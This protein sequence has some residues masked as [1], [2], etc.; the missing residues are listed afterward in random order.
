MSFY[1]FLQ[2]YNDQLDAISKRKD[3]EINRQS[4]LQD[5]EYNRQ[6]RP[7]NL[8][9]T[10]LRNALDSINV[11][12]ERDTSLLK[13]SE[14]KRKM[15]DS[16]REFDLRRDLDPKVRQLA[17]V[18][19][20]ADIASTQNSVEAAQLDRA[21]TPE[22]FN[23]LLTQQGKPYRVKAVEGGLFALVDGQGN[24]LGDAVPLEQLSYSLQTPQPYNREAY[25]N[26]AAQALAAGKR[27]QGYTVVPPVTGTSAPATNQ[28]AGGTLNIP[29][30]LGGTPTA[31]ALSGNQPVQAA[32]VNPPTQPQ[33]A[34]SQQPTAMNPQRAAMLTPLAV[35]APA[36]AAVNSIRQAF[37]SGGGQP[38]VRSAKDIYKYYYTTPPAAVRNASDNRTSSEAELQGFRSATQDDLRSM[39]RGAR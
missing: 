18:K 12:Y 32:R 29:N 16:I 31:K 5:M 30:I 20:D 11:Q 34:P 2:G 7:L 27:D 9:S 21:V 28:P 8:E 37:G 23:D 17:Q 38:N 15:E 4:T 36:I 10:R 25:G 24:Q 33:G 39:L 6:A 19:A 3:A 13:T 14:F 1:S 22:Q 26:M 35:A